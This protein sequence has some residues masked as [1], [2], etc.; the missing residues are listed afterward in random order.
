MDIWSL[1][2]GPITRF[3][4]EGTIHIMSFEQEEPGIARLSPAPKLNNLVQD[5]NS[6]SHVHFLGR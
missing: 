4:C 2:T 5:L 6:G 1:V 3:G